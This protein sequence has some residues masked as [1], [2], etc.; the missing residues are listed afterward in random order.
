M[1]G[2]LLTYLKLLG[3][4]L[5]WGGTFVA[6]KFATIDSS[7]EMAALLR[8]VIAS[9]ALLLI[10]YLHLGYLPRLNLRQAY[11]VVLL[12]LTGVAV[13][14]LFFFYGLQSVGAGR[15]A[16]IITSNPIWVALGAAWFFRQAIRPWQILGL[17]LCIIGVSIVLS[18]GDVASLLS[19]QIGSGELA[20]LGS[21]LCWAAYT[22]LGKKLMHSDFA[23]DPL[24]LVSYSC[25]SGSLILALWMMI[26]GQAFTAQ[27]SF[28]LVFSIGYLALL[29]TV[30][31][32]VWYFQGVRELGAAQGAVFVFF[33][34]VT[35]IL[36]GYLILDETMTL[37]LLIG[38]AL[39]LSGVY[40]VNRPQD[41]QS[42]PAS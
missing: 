7:I 12:G 6:A 4:V 2:P 19:A 39:I 8:F 33:V 23:L 22:L 15:G 25:V 13:Y 27:P 17:V 30:A 14:N 28:E 5:A 31:G 3:A 35:A 21:A 34:P 38:A 9:L 16:L 29:G 36:L 42:A 37:S 10:L 41:N 1:P 32:F 40:L 20:L 24:A 26:S 11:Y 18:R